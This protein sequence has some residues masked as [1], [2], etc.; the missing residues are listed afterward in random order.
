MNSW[1][2]HAIVLLADH[3]GKTHAAPP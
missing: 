2:S 3:A 1:L